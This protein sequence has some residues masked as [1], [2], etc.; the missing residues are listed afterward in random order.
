[1][2]RAVVLACIFALAAT[3]AW[4][5]EVATWNEGRFVLPDGLCGRLE[6][7][8]A[9]RIRRCVGGMHPEFYLFKDAD[10]PQSRATRRGRLNEVATKSRN[11]GMD[12]IWRGFARGYGACSIS[13]RE[14][15]IE[16]GRIADHLTVRI[17]GICRTMSSATEVKSYTIAT[18]VVTS[19]GKQI[20]ITGDFGNARDATAGVALYRTLVQNV[21]TG[22]RS[23]P[24]APTAKS[25]S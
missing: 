20:M 10:P 11:G 14:A 5:R 13:N 15:M 22:A 9:Y 24:S 3:A 17:T 18:Y 6:S 8:G 7:D 21:V 19:A 12:N 4:G 25:P 2:A 16:N 23:T 1:M